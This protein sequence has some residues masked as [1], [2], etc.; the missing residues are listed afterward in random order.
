MADSIR[1]RRG[2]GSSPLADGEPGWNTSTHTL[3]VGQGGINYPVGGTTSPLTTKGDV[4]VYDI[5]NARLP[6]G[7][8]GAVLTADSTQAAGL[9]YSSDPHSRS[10]MGL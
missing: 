7:P 2:T 3:Y 4:Y 5:G 1:F 8:D 9:R 10:W 6:V